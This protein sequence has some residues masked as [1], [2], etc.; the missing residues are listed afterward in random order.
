MKP[1]ISISG[2]LKKVAAL[3]PEGTVAEV[4][5]TGIGFSLNAFPEARVLAWS[6]S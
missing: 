5:L 2:R 3:G 4:K 1:R 6:P